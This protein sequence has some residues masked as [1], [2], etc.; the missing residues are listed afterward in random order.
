M[1]SV[2]LSSFIIIYL[3]ALAVL[4]VFFAINFFHIVLT[5]TTSFSSFLITLFV[6]ASVTLILYGTWYFL[7]GV[8]LSQ[9]ITIWNNSWLGRGNNLF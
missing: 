3:I 2:P 6:L 7:Q 9:Q 1:L 4:G 5:G 8:D